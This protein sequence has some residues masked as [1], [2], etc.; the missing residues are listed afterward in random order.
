[1]WIAVGGTPQ[2]VA[3]A[4][5]LGLPLAI[6][7]I[8]GQPERIEPLVHLY[9]DTATRAGHDAATLPVGINSHGFVADDSKTAA[10]TFYPTY[11]EVMT[12]LGRERGWPPTT[13]AQ[14]DAQRTLRGALLVG[15]PEEVAEKILFQHEFF[16][17]QRF[18]LQ[19]SV[20]TLPHAAMLRSIELYGTRVAPVVRAEVARRAGASPHAA[21]PAD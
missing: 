4:A 14:Y 15:S 12:R 1:V 3:R 2:S 8:G 21:T 18:L 19:M 11:A 13:R 7:I 10:D 5:T 20:G 16:G 6:A 17:H 9:R